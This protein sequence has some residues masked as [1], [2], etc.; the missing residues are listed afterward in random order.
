[1]SLPTSGVVWL[2][3]S[4]YGNGKYARVARSRKNDV[5]TVRGAY[6][7]H[8][9]FL[10][11]LVQHARGESAMVT[12]VDF[13]GSNGLES[14]H[15]HPGAQK[16]LDAKAVWNLFRAGWAIGNFIEVIV[17]AQRGHV[18]PEAEKK[19]PQD[20]K[21]VM[22]ANGLLR[23]PGKITAAYSYLKDSSVFP[24]EGF[25]SYPGSGLLITGKIRASDIR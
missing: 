12:G 25:Y 24:V 5:M 9:N 7:D 14:L 8:Q 23:A 15:Y 16:L 13:D 20:I 18:D 11:S 17:E 10:S 2:E 3:T 4:P 21:N 22:A 1:M 19:I 6:Y